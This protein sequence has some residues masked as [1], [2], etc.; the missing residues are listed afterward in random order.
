MEEAV[1]LRKFAP[2]DERT[3]RGKMLDSGGSRRAGIPAA[4]SVLRTEAK[5]AALLKRCG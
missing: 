1:H 4:E 2:E 3:T 5:T